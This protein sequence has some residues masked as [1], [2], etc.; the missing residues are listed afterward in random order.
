[1]DFVA[2][3][4]S[5][6]HHSFDLFAE[7]AFDLHD[8]IRCLCHPLKVLFLSI[9]CQNGEASQHFLLKVCKTVVYLNSVD[10]VLSDL[11]VYPS[12]KAFVV[13]F[14]GLSPPLEIAGHLLL[15]IVEMLDNIFSL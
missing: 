13:F 11:T 12:T 3:I 2:S 9:S 1:M 7:T 15:N 5:R 4:I 8:G 14:Y 10:H 6:V